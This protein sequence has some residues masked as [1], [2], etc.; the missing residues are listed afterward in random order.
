MGSHRTPRPFLIN[1]PR[2]HTCHVGGSSAASRVE[3]YVSR[4]ILQHP[5]TKLGITREGLAGNPRPFL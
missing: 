5:H 2:S 4:E 1:D 3:S